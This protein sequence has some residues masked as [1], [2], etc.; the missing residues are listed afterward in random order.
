MR[1]FRMETILSNSSSRSPSSSAVFFASASVEMLL[2]MQ[3]KFIWFTTLNI[4]SAFCVQLLSKFIYERIPHE[5]NSYRTGAGEVYFT[6]VDMRDTQHIDSAIKE[7]TKLIYCE[8]P[9]N[10]MMNLVDLAAISKIAR[11]TNLVSVVDNTF[12]SPYFQNPLDFG[13][14]IVL[15]SA[16]K[17]IGGHSDV[18]GGGVITSVEEYAEKIKIYQNTARAVPGPW[19]VWLLVRSVKKLWLRMEA[20]N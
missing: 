2:V 8:T 6:Y 4:F 13:I 12:M 10:P 16:T 7:N 19:D 14:D 3:R 1:S 15:H 5:S 17:Y 11:S 20:H 9:T 18:I